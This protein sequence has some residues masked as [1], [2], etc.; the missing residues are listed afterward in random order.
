M[1]EEKIQKLKKE[2]NLLDY[3]DVMKITGWGR[4]RV[5]LLMSK[6]DFP[7]IKVGRTKQVTIEG[8]K[9]YLSHRTVLK[10]E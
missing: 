6:K 2:L 9:E 5:R 1:P 4:D 3:R 10:E 7:L 8:L